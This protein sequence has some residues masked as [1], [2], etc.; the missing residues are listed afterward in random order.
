MDVPKSPLRQDA[1]SGC[2]RRDSKGISEIT[3]T[4][5][6]SRW[7]GQR[8]ED[9][10]LG[11]PSPDRRA[12]GGPAL[13]PASRCSARYFTDIFRIG[14]ATARFGVLARRPRT[15]RASRH[16]LNSCEL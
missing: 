4:T 15:Q 7:E 12:L 5:A 14:T 10:V 13:L 6:R 8:R 2:R 3:S 1:E 16:I 11:T 9:A